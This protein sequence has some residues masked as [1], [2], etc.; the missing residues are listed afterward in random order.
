MSISVI[1]VV[2]A[3]VVTF[4]VLFVAYFN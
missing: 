3:A 1:G 4:G 2:V